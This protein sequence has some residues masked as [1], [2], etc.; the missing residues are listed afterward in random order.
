LV[1]FFWRILWAG[2]FYAGVLPRVTGPWQEGLERA[3]S[4]WPVFGAAALLNHFSKRMGKKRVLDS[5]GRACEIEPT[6]FGPHLFSIFFN[7]RVVDGS[8]GAKPGV[9][10]QPLAGVSPI[11][12]KR[13]DRA[14]AARAHAGYFS[15]HPTR[16]DFDGRGRRIGN[17]FP[18]AAAHRETILAARSAMSG[19]LAALGETFFWGT[20]LPFLRRLAVGDVIGP[21]GRLVSL[22][23]FGDLTFPPVGEKPWACGWGIGGKLGWFPLGFVC[24]FSPLCLSGGGGM[25]LVLLQGRF[26]SLTG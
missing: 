18:K 5:R 26:L 15:T 4:L 22:S 6:G 10:L 17:G 21:G 14:H 3:W 20:W 2:L 16:R 8:A 9:S 12:P 7:S 24:G 11:Y 19:P 25:V 1:L 23:V 13:E